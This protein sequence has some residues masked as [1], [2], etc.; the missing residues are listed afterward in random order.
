ME[1][2]SL[3]VVGRP[4]LLVIATLS[5]AAAGTHFAVIQ[6]HLGEFALFGFLF[7][8]LSWF[9]AVWPI[10][11]IV[12]RSTWLGWIGV[13]INFGAIAVWIWSRTASLPVGPDPGQ[14]EPVG[15]LDLTATGLEF[16]LGI[17][18]IV[19]LIPQ[20]RGPVQRVRVEPRLAWLAAISITAIV[21]A[22]TSLALLGQ[23]AGPV[24]H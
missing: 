14:P 21:V 19:L 3:S 23:N 20:L 7:L 11:Y 16:V 10:L 6:E 17:L 2:R 5:V 12:R 22:V 15:P 24:G 9:R 18:L 1:N 13:L 4:L 8:A